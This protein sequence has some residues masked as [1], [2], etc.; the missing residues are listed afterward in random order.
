MSFRRLAERMRRPGWWRA[1]ALLAL[2]LAAAGCHW[3]DG[4]DRPGMI[5]GRAQAEVGGVFLPLSDVRV[6]A[7]GATNAVT[8]TRRDGGFT[9]AR[10]NEGPHTVQLQALHGTY[11]RSVFVHGKHE[12]PFVVKPADI[13]AALF[14]ELSGLKRVDVDDDGRL[15]WYYGELVRWEKPL[16]SVY[17]D[18]A[19]AP[20][21]VDWRTVEE[22]R[23][24]LERWEAYLGNKVRFT[25][26]NSPEKADI[27]VQWAPPDSMWPQVGVA[28][29][30]ARYVDGS[31][32]RV[33]IE[34]DAA[35]A[36]YPGLW[37]HELAHA[38]GVMH[39]SDP[40]SVMYPI[41][42]GDQRSTLSPREVD[43]VRLMYDVPSGQRLASGLRVAAEGWTEPEAVEEERPSGV[44]TGVL[45]VAPD[46]RP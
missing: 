18:L 22:Y 21:E 17:M 19:T 16:V 43:H 34:I 45:R 44:R 29:H 42:D 25:K 13:S 3:L 1:L 27:Y 41:L 7:S 9:L 24:E 33:D 37:A 11:H 26:A 23:K 6:A 46:L 28:R 32:K 35:W 8:H 30:T 5:Y 15:F 40:S 38:M 20:P 39:V 36:R 31:L 10:L 2:A 4:G 14:F 12:L